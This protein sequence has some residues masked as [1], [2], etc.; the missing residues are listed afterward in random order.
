LIHIFDGEKVWHQVIAPMQ[1]GALFASRHTA[2]MAS[3]VVSTGLKTTLTGMAGESL[4]AL[5]I[6]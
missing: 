4:K 1:R 5:A 6:S 3:G 2:E